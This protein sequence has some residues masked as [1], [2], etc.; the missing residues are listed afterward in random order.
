MSEITPNQRYDESPEARLRLPSI[1]PDVAASLARMKQLM[2][3]R[4]AI[5]ALK[6]LIGKDDDTLPSSARLKKASPPRVREKVKEKPV[7]HYQNFPH[8]SAKL[9]M[10]EGAQL[11]ALEGKREEARKL[12]PLSR[13]DLPK[14]QAQC[15]FYDPWNS[16]IPL[17]KIQRGDL[18]KQVSPHFKVKDMV[19]I[20]P[21]DLYLVKSG[22]YRKYKGEYYRTVA[23]IDPELVKMLEQVYEKMQPKKKGTPA[24]A[25]LGGTVRLHTNEG[26][27][28]YG[29]N[30]RT[31]WRECHGNAKC[32]HENSPHTAGRGVDI[33]RKP[34][35]QDVCMEVVQERGSGGI[36]THGIN[37]VHLDSRPGTIAQWDYHQSKRKPKDAGNE[38]T[39]AA[40]E[41][42]ENGIIK[43][44]LKK[45]R[46]A[47]A[48]KI[49]GK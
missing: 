19:R 34:G 40:P 37:I 18:E 46:D 17:V 5:Q 31:Y 28:P 42:N 21:K 38:K 10:I 16:G 29:E 41:K 2:Y 26:Y 43:G 49:S 14:I 24:G 45:I 13:H 4:G 27:R 35:L 30:A 47:I 12:N 39:P 25:S 11:I 20:D 6:K 8:G 7:L 23:R 48:R 44:T 15:E 3:S 32:T 9:E 1:I 36:G 22:F 33:D